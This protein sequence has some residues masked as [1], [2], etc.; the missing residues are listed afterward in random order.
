[1]LEPGGERREEEDDTEDDEEA[2]EEA[3]VVTGGFGEEPEFEVGRVGSVLVTEPELGREPL[4]G[5]AV[6]FL[7][8]EPDEGR[9]GCVVDETLEEGLGVEEGLGLEEGIGEDAFGRLEEGGDVGVVVVGG[10]LEVELT[11]CTG[12]DGSGLIED[13][14]ETL[15]LTG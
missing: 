1:L 15:L 6:S 12:G 9:D 11:R 3:I 4:G 7:G 8:T 13:G 14:F 2:P 5:G 10:I